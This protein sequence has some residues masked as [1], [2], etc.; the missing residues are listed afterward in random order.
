MLSSVASYSSS[1]MW[2]SVQMVMVLKC[3]IRYFSATLLWF[4]VSNYSR[5]TI[6]TPRLSSHIYYNE[7]EA[8]KAR[9]PNNML[10]ASL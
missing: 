8:N 6:D 1:M 2:Q 10:L 3:R 5:H 7:L 4:K 9:G